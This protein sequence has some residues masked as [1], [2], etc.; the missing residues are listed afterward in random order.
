MDLKPLSEVDLREAI[1]PIN[2]AVT[3]HYLPSV[4]TASQL[5]ER[6][7]LGLLDLRLSRCAF[8]NRE[9]VGACLVERVDDHAHLDAIG[10][11]P[12][13]QQRGVGHALLEAACV[14]AEATGVR[15][16]SAEAPESDAAALATLQSAGFRWHRQL[17]RWALQ[18]QP[19]ALPLPEEVA[20]DP[21]GTGSQ[22]ALVAGQT[23]IRK[24]QLSEALEFL[25]SM[26]APG[27]RDGRKPSE[28]PFMRQPAVL[29][30][31]EGKLSAFLL[32]QLES[33]EPVLG[34]AIVERDR[35]QL[36]CLGGE[37]ERVAPLVSL[38]LSR[39]GVTQAD[40]VPD[41]DAAASALLAAGLV[42]VAVR[43]ELLRLLP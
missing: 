33:H 40:P 29:R 12:L 31:L 35:H 42:R 17:S 23:F 8:I 37:G 26:T 22:L 39:H 43:C 34:A 6:A 13:S 27:P 38:L 24:V 1:G 16:F 21:R 2:R 15:V 28:P 11:E 36:L 25:D 20:D 3:G 18:G 30:R 19:A 41:Q 32:L 9:L 14:A 7:A 10:V 5:R 4:R